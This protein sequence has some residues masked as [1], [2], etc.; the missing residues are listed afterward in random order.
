[1]GG[2]TSTGTSR[3][4]SRGISRVTSGGISR[5]TSRGAFTAAVPYKEGGIGVRFSNTAGAG[6]LKK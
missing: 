4:I 5:V 2:G 1:M 6:C 3:V